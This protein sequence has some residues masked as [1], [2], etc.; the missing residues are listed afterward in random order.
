MKF[1]TEIGHRNP[2][3]HPP[4][5]PKIEATGTGGEQDECTL[6]SVLGNNPILFF[7]LC[8]AE[9]HLDW[10]QPDEPILLL[11]IP[12]CRLE[13]PER[14]KSKGLARIIFRKGLAPLHENAAFFPRVIHTLK[15]KN[16]CLTS[17]YLPK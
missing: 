11:E 1:V 12:L 15:T 9:A 13:N 17:R 16:Y 2:A 4:R 5:N 3:A 10:N 14:R 7:W 8:L 6:K